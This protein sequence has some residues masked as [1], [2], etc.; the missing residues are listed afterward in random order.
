MKKILVTCLVLSCFLMGTVYAA[1]YYVATDGNDWG[2]YAGTLAKPWQSIWRVKYAMSLNTFQ[3]GDTIHLR[4]G[5]TWNE[6]LSISNS[7]A[8]GNPITF[9]RY[10]GCSSN[11][12]NNPTLGPANFWINA[13]ISNVH[14]IRI[15]NI[16]FDGAG[17]INILVGNSSNIEINNCTALNSGAQGI[18][19]QGSS[20]DVIITDSKISNPKERGIFVTANAANINNI[21]IT[22]NNI[23]KDNVD[24]SLSNQHG[25]HLLA[26]SPFVI[27]N[28][29]ISK[30]IID[31]GTENQRFGD[32]GIWLQPD[33]VQFEDNGMPVPKIYFRDFVISR[34][35]V[36][37]AKGQAISVSHA[38]LSDPSGFNY[39]DK[40]TV[41]ENGPYTVNSPTV[42]IWVGGSYRV[43]ISHNEVFDN[44]GYDDVITVPY[45]KYGGYDNVG[46]YL[47]SMA[48]ECIVRYNTV[49]GHDGLYY[50]FPFYDKQG[51]ASGAFS[52]SGIG[53]CCGAHDNEIYYN[54]SYGNKIGLSMSEASGI[55]T[56]YNPVTID[57][58]LNEPQEFYVHSHNNKIYNNVF[59]YNELGVAYGVGYVPD[60]LTSSLL[61]PDIQE[62]VP[63]CG[64][65]HYC[66]EFENNIFYNNHGITINDGTYTDGFGASLLITDGATHPVEDHNIFFGNDEDDWCNILFC[67]GTNLSNN[68]TEEPSFVNPTSFNFR[69]TPDS[70]AIN[71]GVDIS[72]SIT[73]ID[74][75]DYDGTPVP[76]GLAPDIGAYE[77]ICTDLDHDGFAIEGGACGPV[78]C[79]DDYLAINPGVSDANCDGTDN[80]CNGQIDDG[81]IP[82]PVTC[83]QGVCAVTWQ[84]ICQG[85]AIADTCIPGTPQ[86]EICDGLDNDCDGVTD[87]YIHG[88][89]QSPINADGSSIF[90]LGRTIP[91]KIALSDCN[92]QNVSTASVTISV[93]WMSNADA[94]TPIEVYSS[95]AANTGSYFRY[96]VDAQ[97]YIYNLSTASYSNGKYKITAHLDNGQDHSV[98]ISSKEQ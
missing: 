66:N 35:T 81:Y 68:T 30:N 75:F 69:L 94:G 15:E 65:S 91:V 93:N 83:G 44:V 9:T 36:R 52:S 70:P 42:G 23:K 59:A 80:N 98:N 73:D 26:G 17:Y 47:D 76:Q 74:L 20:H 11:G 12:S 27:E 96:D 2:P 43:I 13:Q 97:Q 53:I 56:V 86:A 5:D 90:K 79:N 18:Q 50:R 40:N 61:N 78:D 64:D 92:G 49:Y 87:E 10:G 4:C 55:S 24:P 1:D 88:S 84:N 29:L 62:V 45:R 38:N 58:Q 89:F 34:N 7:G 67:R 41:Y 95:G 32:F 71:A 31:L 51:S 8:E 39:I 16:T 37:H 3:P 63:D 77:F 57:G 33:G 6:W 85:G 54:V 46:I 25:I 28:I 19:V 48:S 72:G 82:T 21:T 60:W 22:D 14:H